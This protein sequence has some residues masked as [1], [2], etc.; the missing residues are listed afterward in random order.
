MLKACTLHPGA[1]A[2]ELGL[3]R[4]VTTTHQ[5]QVSVPGPAGVGMYASG[6]RSSATSLFSP[7][8]KHP[9]NLRLHIQVRTY[10]A[11]LEPRVF[12]IATQ[13]NRARKNALMRL[14]TLLNLG[15]KPSYSFLDLS[16][17]KGLMSCSSFL[18]LLCRAKKRRTPTSCSTPA[19]WTATLPFCLRKSN[20][21]S[22]N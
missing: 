6:T 13:G 1:P 12:R 21:A 2:R 20:L 15:R 5:L 4:I 17:N 3:K 8:F 10:M 16:S 7:L 9:G 19:A 22:E 11:W 18:N 14:Q